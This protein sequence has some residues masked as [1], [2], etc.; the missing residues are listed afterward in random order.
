MRCWC[1]LVFER[2]TDASLHMKACPQSADRRVS[3][4]GCLFTSCPLCLRPYRCKF[5]SLTETPED[6]T[7]IVDEEGFKGL[8]SCRH[9]NALCNVWS[10]F[11]HTVS[12]LHAL[13]QGDLSVTVTTTG[14]VLILLTD[15]EV[16]STPHLS[17]SSNMLNLTDETQHL[18]LFWPG[19]EN[20]SMLALLNVQISLLR[21]GACWALMLTH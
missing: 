20:G 2:L 5:F 11:E 10:V 19:P 1:L 7:I 18:C 12:S 21:V 3:L 4:S 9:G 17:D 16:I 13:F 6:Y 14:Q 15:S 8:W